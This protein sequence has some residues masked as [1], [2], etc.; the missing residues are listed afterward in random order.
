MVP[1]FWPNMLE[2]RGRLGAGW[3]SARFGLSS[4]LRGHREREGDPR[5]GRPSPAPFRSFQEETWKYF[6][7]ETLKKNLEEIFKKYMR[8]KRRPKT[9]KQEAERPI[10]GSDPFLSSCIFFNFLCPYMFYLM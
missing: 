10:K 6:Q 2:H 8:G 9:Q 3:R 7:E 1:I 4:Q 5:P